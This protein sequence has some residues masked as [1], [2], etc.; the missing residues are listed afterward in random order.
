MPVEVLKSKIPENFAQLVSDHRLALEKHRFTVNVPAPRP[1]GELAPVI[2]ACVRRVQHPIKAKKPDDYVEDYVI[3]DDT[4]PP[5][6]PL[7]LVERKERLR[8]Q[9]RT[10]ESE[11]HDRLLSPGRRQLNAVKMTQIQGLV[12]ERPIT[13]DEEEF[14][15]AEQARS[16][17]HT[18]ISMRA[19]EMMVEIDDLTEDTVDQWAPGA[20]G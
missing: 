13:K 6:P 14:L 18:D 7:T 9:V 20:I 11:A 4:P 16:R 1:A 8:Q 5:P 12:S 19:A 2:E 3:V 17:L 15:K 10:L